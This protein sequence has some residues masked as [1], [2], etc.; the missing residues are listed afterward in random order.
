MVFP[1]GNVGH[2]AAG[3]A[4]QSSGF[5][6]GHW[7]RMP[8]RSTKMYTSSGVPTAGLVTE[9]KPASSSYFMVDFTATFLLVQ[10]AVSKRP[11]CL[12]GEVLGR[13][14]LCTTDCL[15]ADSCGSGAGRDLAASL[16]DAARARQRG[17]PAQFFNGFVN[18][19]SCV[20]FCPDFLRSSTGV[21]R[22]NTSC[23]KQDRRSGLK[24]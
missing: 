17:N 16:S 18:W 21:A 9:K 7:M 5:S 13:R 10:R 20:R 6:A 3:F 24:R 8:L 15:A 12:L 22:Q 19:K 2:E 11:E 1:A 23:A 14:H 4:E